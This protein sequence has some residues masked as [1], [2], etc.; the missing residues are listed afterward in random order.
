MPDGSIELT[1]AF[2]SYQQRQNNKQMGKKIEAPKHI[3]TLGDYAIFHL[4]SNNLIK[5][6]LFWNSSLAT[7]GNPFPNQRSSAV[8]VRA[9]PYQLWNTTCPPAGQQPLTSTEMHIDLSVPSKIRNNHSCSYMWKNV[10][11]NRL[12]YL[13]L[14]IKTRG[15]MSG[16]LSIPP[17]HLAIRCLGG[18]F[19]HQYVQSVSLFPFVHLIWK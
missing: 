15:K 19:T 2:A 10:N 4:P 18:T 6:K 8:L 16:S 7:P 12:A 13:Q 9:G 17:C 5:R 1:F 14:S 11:A 3:S